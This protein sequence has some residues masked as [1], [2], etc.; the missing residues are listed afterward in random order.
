MTGASSGIG[1]AFAERLA[2]DD[3]DLVVVARRRERLEAL[4]RRLHEEHGIE[5]DVLAADLADPAGLRAVEERIRRAPDLEM[6]VNNAGFSGYMPF[7]ELDPDLAERLIRLQV[8]APT[9]L[10]RAALPEMIAGGGGTVIVVSSALGFSASASAAPLPKRATYAAT[11]AYLNAFTM[12]L[13]N[14]LQGTGLRMQV[15]CPGVVDT[16]FHS[17]ADLARHAAAGIRRMKPQAVVEASLAG[18]RLG[19][20]ICMPGLDDPALISQYQERERSLL[21][22]SIRAGVLAKRYTDGG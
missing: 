5:V 8:V 7:V 20:V 10:T 9:R 18:L 1:A 6:L 2:T 16:E 17:E 13:H 11:K 14:E 22:S 19:E 3:Y 21:Q 15:L 4:A 12:L